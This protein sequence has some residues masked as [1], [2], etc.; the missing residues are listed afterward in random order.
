MWMEM[1]I[2]HIANSAYCKYTGFENKRD[3]SE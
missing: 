3:L 1:S 2:P